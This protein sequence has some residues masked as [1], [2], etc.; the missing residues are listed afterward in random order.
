VAAFKYRNSTPFWT[1]NAGG[2]VQ[3]VTVPCV[4]YRL[5]DSAAWIGF[6]AFEAAPPLVDPAAE[7]GQWAR[8]SSVSHS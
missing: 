2:W 7:S 3:N 4:I 1:G 6:A 8:V 5:T